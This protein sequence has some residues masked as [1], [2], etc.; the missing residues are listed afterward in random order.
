MAGKM[1]GAQVVIRGLEFDVVHKIDDPCAEMVWLEVEPRKW[2][3][4]RLDFWRAKQKAIEKF[5]G[6]ARI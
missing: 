1:N 6:E 3:R 4:L 5:A 2:R